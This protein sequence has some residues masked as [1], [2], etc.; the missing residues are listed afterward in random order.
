[1]QEEDR[2]SSCG[3]SYFRIEDIVCRTSTAWGLLPSENGKLLLA[4]WIF[5]HAIYFAIAYIIATRAKI[6]WIPL[7]VFFLYVHLHKAWIFMRKVKEA[8]DNKQVQYK[9]PQQ[10]SDEKS[11]QKSP[12]TL[13]P[14]Q[15]DHDIEMAVST[16]A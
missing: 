9:K 10:A 15:D 16:T 6:L 3:K 13:K 8:N 11:P 12:E 7:A 14:T 5:R 4:F 2:M 1:M